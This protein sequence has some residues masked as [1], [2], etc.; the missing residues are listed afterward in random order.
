VTMIAATLADRINTAAQLVD[1]VNA[2][3][4]FSA[5]DWSRI[6]ADVH[7]ALED[8]YR[9]A[10]APR[11]SGESFDN[12]TLIVLRTRALRVLHAAEEAAGKR[13]A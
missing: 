4:S 3:A 11:K 9:Q 5:S 10:T 8:L 7:A 6:C 12:I 2:H 1:D 13:G